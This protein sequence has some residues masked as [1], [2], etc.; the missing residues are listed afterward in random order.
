MSVDPA[1]AVLM[2]VEKDNFIIPNFL[3]G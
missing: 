2:A 1:A 3:D